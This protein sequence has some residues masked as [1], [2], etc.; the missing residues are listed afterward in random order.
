MKKKPNCFTTRI[1][2]STALQDPVKVLISVDGVPV[3]SVP[4]LTWRPTMKR[5]AEMSVLTKSAGTTGHFFSE[6]MK[7]T[8]LNKCERAHELNT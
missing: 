3:A 6:R 7:T 5:L 4:F 8:I 1:R 2:L